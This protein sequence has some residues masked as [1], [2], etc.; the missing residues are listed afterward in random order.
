VSGAWDEELCRNNLK[1]IILA[2]RDLLSTVGCFG[3][4]FPYIDEL[5]IAE[6]ELK[7]KQQFCD[8]V[9]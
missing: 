8:L 5:N 1:F 9:N 2:D 6:D 3:L 4:G 7:R